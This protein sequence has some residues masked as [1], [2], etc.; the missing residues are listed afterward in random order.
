MEARECSLPTTVAEVFAAIASKSFVDWRFMR[1]RR[2]HGA[3][4]ERHHYVTF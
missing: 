1:S 3:E 4:G 2:K